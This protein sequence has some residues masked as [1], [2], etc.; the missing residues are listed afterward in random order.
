M[1]QRGGGPWGWGQVAEQRALLARLWDSGLV[2]SPG[3][4]VPHSLDGGA[5][6]RP[7]SPQ[8]PLLLLCEWVHAAWSPST[9]S[10]AGALS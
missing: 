2:T 8:S 6:Q 4:S 9:R 1:L 3:S 10:G 7:W 5:S